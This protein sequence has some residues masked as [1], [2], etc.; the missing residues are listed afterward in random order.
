MYFTRSK[1]ASE[2]LETW[3]Y[4]CIYNETGGYFIRRFRS[5]NEYGSHLMSKSFADKDI[6][7]KPTVPDNP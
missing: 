6:Q 3:N 1:N 4:Y 7:W 2:T 5:N